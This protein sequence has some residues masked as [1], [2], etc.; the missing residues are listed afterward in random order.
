MK[1]Y[2]LSYWNRLGILLFLPITFTCAAQTKHGL[3]DSIA[4]NMDRYSIAN[5]SSTLFVHFD[6][7][8]YSNFENVWFEAYLLNY[9][10]SLDSVNIL[11]VFL[12]RNND[13]SI[14][15]ESQFD[16]R[17][18]LASGHMFLP[19]TLPPGNFSFIAYTN[20][21]VNG[22][23]D[24]IFVQPIT[25]KT[26]MGDFNLSLRLASTG[27]A[28]K[29]FAE[30][31][32]KAYSK[33]FKTLSNAKFRYTVGSNNPFQESSTN[34]E[35]ERRF[36]LPLNQVESA[37]NI[38]HVE[39]KDGL[40]FKNASL[41]I[42]VQR[43][44][45]SVKF[46]PEGGN[47]V[48][49]TSIV[50]GFEVKNDR[51]E[52]LAISG[53]LYESGHI[54]DTIST[55]EDGIGRFTITAKKEHA[56]LVK[57]IN[58]SLD[59]LDY[60]L[61]PVLPTIPVITVLN[62][63]AK[64][65]LNVLLKNLNSAD[66]H[67]Y[68]LLHDYKTLFRG[69]EVSKGLATQYVQLPLNDIPKGVFTVTLLDQYKRPLAE[70]ICFAHINRQ[71]SIS[72][73]SDAPVYGSRKKV[74][75]K[76]TL[77]GEDQSTEGEFSI[78]CVQSNRIEATKAKDIQT[79]TYVRHQM[80]SLPKGHLLFSADGTNYELL[81]NSLLVK[82]WRKYTWLDMMNAK[83]LK[84]GEDKMIFNGTIKKNNRMIKESIEVGLLNDSALQT[85][86]TDNKGHFEL[87]T[88][89]LI[90]PEGKKL[91]LF[92]NGKAQNDYDIKIENPFYAA[93]RRIIKEIEFENYDILEK[94]SSM[95][96]FALAKG[97][98]A[99]VLE[100]VTIKAKKDDGNFYGKA[101]YNRKCTDYVCQ[102]GVLNCPNHIKDP[103][104]TR[105]INGHTYL[106]YSSGHVDAVVYY[107][108]CG[109]TKNNKFILNIDGIYMSKVFY[110]TDLSISKT[111]NPEYL[112]TL[113]WN[114][115]VHLS[116]GNSVTIPFYTGDIS[117]RF[118]VVVQGKTDDDV[119]IGQ[120]FFV[121]KPDE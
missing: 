101:L 11:S 36:H 25:V 106:S 107:S 100:A 64:D 99:K 21:L 2:I 43:H 88:N 23:P 98:Y 69:F 78:A 108:D 114:P 42:P 112:S 109:I 116:D 55:N 50:V 82:G 63:V 27:I 89:N 97:E 41:A 34:K 117:G 44:A 104:N 16:M 86:R 10:N 105:P 51:G 12:V 33:D 62:A 53:F 70:R 31:Y 52:P 67:L 94:D 40:L 59:R 96:S 74:L 13:R 75:L 95:H 32:L 26:I 81:E 3:L 54:I 58:D 90:T 113:Y 79:Y 110:V 17:D 102:Y 30:I 4:V 18:G 46:Y 7:T 71:H 91:L 8:V 49:S 48:E 22:Y 20:H 92:V 24:D 28:S 68:V 87:S 84:Q 6:K 57:I 77:K 103:G 45:A 83:D 66:Q 9:D 80:A 111:P 65:T 38:L 85:I 19:D 14:W 29:D 39:M 5:P 76:I 47:L 61:P 60:P 118:T 93:N 15:M 115:R 73:T 37:N 120:Y 56:Y 119:V 121:V 35:G 1:R 72:I